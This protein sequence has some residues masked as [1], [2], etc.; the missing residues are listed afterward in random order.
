M[1]NTLF[2]KFDSKPMVGTTFGC[3]Q[4]CR[5]G[6]I[7][8]HLSMAT[9]VVAWFVVRVII[10][11][12]QHGTNLMC[13]NWWS[14]H[15]GKSL[16]SSPSALLRQ[17]YLRC[18]TTAG[19]N[20]GMKFADLYY[21]FA[22][23][24]AA[25]GVLMA[26]FYKDRPEQMGLYPD[27]GTEPPLSATRDDDQSRIKIWDV[28]KRGD[29]W[30]LIIGFGIYYL[31]S[32]AYCLLR[33]RNYHQRRYPAFYLP[34]LAAGAIV[35]C[36]VSCWVSSTTVGYSRGLHRDGVFYILGFWAWLCSG[37][38]P[39]SHHYGR[40]WLRCYYRLPT[41]PPSTPTYAAVRTS[42]QLLV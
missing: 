20:I 11:I 26:I 27:G 36:S 34:A 10:V 40:C 16:V 4:H 35:V 28:L 31:A 42:W 19:Q 22:I 18:L 25:I 13:T 37:Q 24:I 41:H 7:I 15:R 2:M 12:L 30:L 32:P 6:P 3:R 1:I 23:V 9:F 8:C 33:R 14:R 21:V 17:R 38:R 5:H 39:W 29:S